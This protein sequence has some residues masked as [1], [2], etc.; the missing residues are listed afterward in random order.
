VDLDD[1]RRRHAEA[2]RALDA[3]GSLDK[4]DET[5]TVDDLG[6]SGILFRREDREDLLGFA[7]RMLGPLVEYERRQR[8]NLL[9]TLRV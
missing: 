9:A 4:R 5:V 7:Q 1:F 6:I 2:R 3:L 8:S